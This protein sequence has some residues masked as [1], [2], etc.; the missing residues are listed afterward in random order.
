[1]AEELLRLLD[2]S[3]PIEI[4]K[5]GIA[6]TMSLDSLFATFRSVISAI[7]DIDSFHV[8]LLPLRTEQAHISS[9]SRLSY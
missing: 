4:P 1:M 9:L 3:L 6:S 5:Y 2:R 7:G 8:A